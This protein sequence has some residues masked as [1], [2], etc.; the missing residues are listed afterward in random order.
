MKKLLYNGTIYT[1]TTKNETVEA[2]IIH[3]GNIFYAG[4]KNH[5][6]TLLQNENYESIDLHNKVLLPGF[7][8]S[9]LHI[10]GHGEKILTVSLSA[11]KS[12]EEILR[13]LQSAIPR[14]GLILAE[15]LHDEL[16]ITK[17]D[18]DYWF[19]EQAVALI[20]QCY[21]TMLVNE[22]ALQKWEVCSWDVLKN[23][24][25]RNIDGTMNGFLYES[26]MQQA[27]K[28]CNTYTLTYLEQLLETAIHSAHSYGITSIV[29]EDLS[30]YGD[31]RI[32]LQAFWNVL[33][34]IAIK[35]H[36]LVHNQ[37]WEEAEAENAQCLFRHPF[38][39]FDSIKFFLDGSLGSRTAWLLQPYSDDSSN[40]GIPAYSDEDLE[41]QIQH[42]RSK[43]KTVAFHVIGDA[44]FEMALSVLKKYPPALKNQKDRLIHLSLLPKNGMKE[45]KQLPV[46]L[47]LQPAFYA[48]DR[49]WIVNRLGM[50]RT[51]NAYQLSSFIHEGFICGGS[52]DSPIEEINPWVG[53]F[54]SIDR[55]TEALTLYEA[56]CLYTKG[57]A[58]TIHAKRGEIKVGFE[59]DFQIYEQDPFQTSLHELKQLRPTEVYVHGQR[60]F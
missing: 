12:K 2:L 47:D 43:N 42:V 52:S 57:S 56:I 9:H 16:H 60:V 22:A 38:I 36:L 33:Q 5:C 8:D 1:M 25:G 3:E 10:I 29:T 32:T 34:K 28:R 31:W 15:G 55:D 39:Q 6:L 26:A 23:E 59:A 27:R 49:N 19:P 7:I 14:D 20:R 11:C 50:E 53:I 13:K 4:N 35:T 51:E 18:L 41:A 44:S 58:A 17:N 30:Y 48:S 24:I 37:V 54:A 46:V 21:H 45:L 40:Y